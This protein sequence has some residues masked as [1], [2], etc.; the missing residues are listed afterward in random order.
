MKVEGRYTFTKSRRDVWNALQD[1]QILASTLPGVKRLEV[2]GPDH[3]AITAHVGVGSVK[4]LFDGDFEV[5]DKQ[6]LESCVLRGNARGASGATSVEAR[7]SLAD[8]DG[9]GTVVTYD[10][11]ASVNGLIAGV[12][13]RMIQAASKRMAHQFFQAVDGYRPGAG[14]AATG[15]GTAESRDFT[16]EAAPPTDARRFAAGV[17]LGFALALVGVIVGRRTAR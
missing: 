14:A 10:A 1:P 4:G 12:G 17:A 7:V 11:D 3:Y 16:R 9:S 13:Q 2:V 6:E 5:S 8:S 15:D